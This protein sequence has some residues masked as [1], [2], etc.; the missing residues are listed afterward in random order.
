MYIIYH[1]HKDEDD[2]AYAF[3][4]PSAQSQLD[5]SVVPATKR[6]MHVFFCLRVHECF[7]LSVRCFQTM[8]FSIRTS[9]RRLLSANL[10]AHPHTDAP[11]IQSFPI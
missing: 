8:P 5:G 4:Y 10:P 1:V 3:T 7:C 2:P 6:P 11:A 9:A